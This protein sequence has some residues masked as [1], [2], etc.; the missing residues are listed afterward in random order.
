MRVPVP[1]R[2]PV[3]CIAL[4]RPTLYL[5]DCP[6]RIALVKQFT[7]APRPST[8]PR[9]VHQSGLCS[10]FFKGIWPCSLRKP[11]AAQTTAQPTPGTRSG[12][13]I[14]RAKFLRLA[15]SLTKGA[16]GRLDVKLTEDPCF[17]TDFGKKKRGCHGWPRFG[18]KAKA[19]T[20][21]GRV[22]SLARCERFEPE[23]MP[24]PR[25]G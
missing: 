1:V 12:T 17:A 21:A 10:A 22:R 5:F 16:G 20:G 23:R 11:A 8:T 24:H 3:L 9:P 25:M 14:D 15:P 13:G 7:G 4:P 19:T 18:T 2:N 6:V